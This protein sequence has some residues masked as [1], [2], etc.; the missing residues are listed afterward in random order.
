MEKKSFRNHFNYEPAKVVARGKLLTVPNMALT[1]QQIIER[2]AKGIPFDTPMRDNEFA[3]QM[4]YAI[5]G[6][7][8]AGMDIV[9]RVDLFEKRRDDFK[10]SYDRLNSKPVEDIVMDKDVEKPVEAVKPAS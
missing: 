6:R 2:F 4:S 7:N 8:F 10:K 5:G 3:E 9:D 1:V